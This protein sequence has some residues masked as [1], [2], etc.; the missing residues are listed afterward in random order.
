MPYS[1]PRVAI[2]TGAARGIGRAIAVRLAAE[3]AAVGV[4]DLD[5]A[6]CTETVDLIRAAGGTAAA[7]RLNVTEEASVTEAVAAVTSELAA[8]TILVNNAGITRDNM[9]FK[10]SVDEWESVMDV[11]LK[12]AFLMS[13]AV[14]GAMV[15]AKWGRIVSLSSLSALGSRG[16]S[17]YSAA[18]A[19]IQGFTRTVAIELGQ[20]GITANA[21]APGF[22]DTDMVR[23]TAER[24][25]VPYEQ[26]VADSAKQIAVRRVG[27]PEDIAALVA[28]LASEES[29]YISGQ[30]IY[31]AGGPTV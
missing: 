30:T 22:V 10:M 24:I 12:G 28:F 31:A 15:A 26:F 29:G 4:A 14:Q 8:P 19:G 17:N 2:V 3:G 16:Q 20:F 27:Q 11:H 5:P 6:S 25:G 9:L 13:K 7:V 21:I 18:K 23:A 1:S